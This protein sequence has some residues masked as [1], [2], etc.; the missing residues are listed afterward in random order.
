MDTS[1]G[2]NFAY[3]WNRT[4]ELLF[5]EMPMKSRE[6]KQLLHNSKCCIGHVFTFSMKKVWYIACREQI[7]INK[8]GE[9]L[10]KTSTR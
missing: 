10:L 6:M 3:L 8:A 1:S 5:L 2:L 7:Q 4:F 9:M